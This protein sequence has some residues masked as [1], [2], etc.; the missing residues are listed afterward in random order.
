MFHDTFNIGGKNIFVV[1]SHHHVLRG[2]AEVR[3]SQPSSPPPA[4]LT[5]DHHTDLEEPFDDHRFYATHQ[6]MT[7]QNAAAKKALLPGMIAAIDWN[8]EATVEA[9]IDKLK[10]DEHIRTAV[11]AGI[12]SRAFVVNL[13][14][15]YIADEEVYGVRADYDE[16]GCTRPNTDPLIEKERIDRVLESM[17]LDHVLA[18]LDSMAQGGGAPAVTAQPYILD[19][20]L[21]YFHSEK[22]IE[23]DDPETF[24]R[25]AQNALAITIA[26]EPGCVKALRWPG[27][28]ITGKTLLA[29][30]EQHLR[31]ALT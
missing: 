28:K 16:I 14:S 5:L 4:L 3:R 11:Q 25:L 30:M 31:T 10:H 19:I 21:D 6:R 29:R 26:T 23:P 17:Y 15:E 9:A 7:D 1:E 22:A 18:S 12:L 13:E 24:Y 8:I 20:D 27:S 2:W